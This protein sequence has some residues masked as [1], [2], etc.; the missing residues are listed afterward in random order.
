M[1]S[2]ESKEDTRPC[3]TD[4]DRDEAASALLG[5]GDDLPKFTDAGI[6][7]TFTTLFDQMGFRHVNYNNNGQTDWH[8][9]AIFDSGFYIQQ[10]VDFLNNNV[11]YIFYK[12]CN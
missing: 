2:E 12:P 10:L 7:H 11:L 3:D 4:A 1:L 6:E 5:L 9:P 8:K